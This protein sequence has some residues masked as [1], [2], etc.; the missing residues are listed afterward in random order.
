MN[1]LRKINY[2]CI[3]ILCCTLLT[4]GCSDDE[5]VRSGDGT[6]GYL[7]LRISSSKIATK[8]VT[9]DK[10][11]DAKKVELSLLYNDMPITQSLNLTSVADAADLGLE[12]EKLELLSGEY[13]LMSY[14]L[15]SDVKPGLEEPE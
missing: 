14:T 5:A 10:L 9:M 4:T 1:L 6:A 15:F 8:A 3:A 12:S 13:Q 11:S 2:L 7:K